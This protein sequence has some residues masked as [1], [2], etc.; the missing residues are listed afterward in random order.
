MNLKSKLFQ[1]KHN[2]DFTGELDEDDRLI[3]KFFEK[4]YIQGSNIRF[5]H[6]RMINILFDIQ[7]GNSLKIKVLN[8]YKMIK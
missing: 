6:H 8:R 4:Y 5:E 7:N 2:D 1:L 3:K